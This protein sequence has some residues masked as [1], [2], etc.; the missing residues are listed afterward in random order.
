MALA[1]TLNL[2]VTC[3]NLFICITL[4][5]TCSKSIWMLKQ[6]TNRTCQNKLF[7]SHLAVVQY[8]K[9]KKSCSRVE[10]SSSQVI[11][12]ALCQNLSLC[13][14]RVWNRKDGGMMC[15]FLWQ[16]AACSLTSL[17]ITKPDNSMATVYLCD[18]I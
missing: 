10:N 16:V 15:P 5:D 4:M 9:K 18:V 7:S 8:C 17:N 13:L 12:S 3:T 6:E 1:W 14:W 2:F 11:L